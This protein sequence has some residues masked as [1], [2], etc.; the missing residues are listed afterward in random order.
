M[1]NK[2]IATEESVVKTRKPRTKKEV[3][4]TPVIENCEVSETEV[5]PAV[6]EEVPYE[7]LFKMGKKPQ[8]RSL[9]INP[10]SKQYSPK[11]AARRLKEKKRRAHNKKMRRM[12]K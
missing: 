6:E 8:V 2:T 12:G 4:E 9:L 7:P 1:T 5:S 3:L 10:N 11:I